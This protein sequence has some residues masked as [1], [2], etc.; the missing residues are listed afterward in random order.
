[1]PKF[2][3]AEIVDNNDTDKEGKVQIKI[4]PEMKDFGQDDYPWARQAKSFS[5]GSNSYGISCIPETN[6]KVW[7]YFEDEIN[8]RNAFYL[9]DLN[10]ESLHPHELYEDDIKSTVGGSASYPDVK[11]LYFK[12][13][14]CLAVSSS[15]SKP[16]VT[17]YHPKAWVHINT[18]GLLEYS[19]NYSNTIKTTTA[20]KIEINGNTK[21]LVTWTELN[22]A[23]QTMLTLLNADI[24]KA[25]GA[26]GTATGNTTLNITSAKTQKLV[27][28]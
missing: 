24:V 19:D 8:F 2:Y 22:T 12:N 6:S 25:N 11:F 13:G 4:L 10:L 18:Q 28:S 3:V 21:E 1:M 20:N 15:D 7:I 14:I 23:L 16:E 5:G 9:F 27:T 17:I 26:G